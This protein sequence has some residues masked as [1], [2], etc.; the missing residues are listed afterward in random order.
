MTSLARLLKYIS[1]MGPGL[2]KE[3]IYENALCVELTKR[4]IRHSDTRSNVPIAAKYK[5]VALSVILFVDLCGRRP[6]N[7]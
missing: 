1:E 7:S 2:L 5:G 4:G 6:G 3:R